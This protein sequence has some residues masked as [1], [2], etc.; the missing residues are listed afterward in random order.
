MRHRREG[1]R[2]T[3]AETARVR[4]AWQVSLNHNH[5]NLLPESIGALANLSMLRLAH[6]R[7]AM[8]PA[9]IGGMVKLKGLFVDFNRLS[10]LPEEIGGLVALEDLNLEDNKLTKIPKS[11]SKGARQHAPWRRHVGTLPAPR[12]LRCMSPSHRHRP[13]PSPVARRPPPAARGA[14]ALVSLKGLYLQNNKLTQMGFVKTMPALRKMSVAGNDFMKDTAAKAA[15]E[16]ELADSG[17][18]VGAANATM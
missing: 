8:L 12:P 11:M 2:V 10:R 16:K 13:S 9:S 6:N 3:G 17:I 7:I 15:V 18:V 5:L 1:T 14:G 4:T